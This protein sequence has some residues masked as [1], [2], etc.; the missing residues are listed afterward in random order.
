MSCWNGVRRASTWE[1]YR[2]SERCTRTCRRRKTSVTGGRLTDCGGR[3]CASACRR[4]WRP[5]GCSTGPGSRRFD[6]DKARGALG[7]LEGVEIVQAE[8]ESLRLAVR[9]ASRKL[10][11]LFAALAAAGAEVRETTMTQPS[12]ESLFIKLTGK[13]LRE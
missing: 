9:E 2:R 7:R 8:T 12:L 5:W 3:S 13:E 1:S 4:C 11:D 6:P 10:P